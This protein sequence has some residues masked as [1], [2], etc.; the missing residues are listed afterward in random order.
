M[1]AVNRA[2]STRL[3]YLR[4][5][6]EIAER[7]AQREPLDVSVLPSDQRA[8]FEAVNREINDARAAIPKIRAEIEELKA[9]QA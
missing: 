2:V 9:W 3:Q 5:E 7:E 1:S 8:P 6:L 4:R